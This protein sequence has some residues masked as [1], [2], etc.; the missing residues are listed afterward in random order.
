MSCSANYAAAVSG[1]CAAISIAPQVTAADEKKPNVLL[2]ITDDQGCGDFGFTGNKTVQTPNIDRLAAESARFSNFVAAPACSPSRTSLMTGRN[3]LKTG[4]WGVGER[5]NQLSD[6]VIMPVFFKAA[7][8]G[9]GYFGKRDGIYQQG[10]GK[11]PWELGWD[12]AVM[13]WGYDHLD[14]RMITPGGVVEKKGWTCDIDVENT[15]DYIRRQNGRPWLCATAFIIPHLPW[16]PDERFAEPFRKTGC[17]KLLADC[18]GSIAQMDAAAGRLLRG[19]DELGCAQNTIIVFLS[20]NGPSYH[21]MSEADIAIRNP[22]HLRDQKASAWENGIRVPLLIRWPSHIPA[23]ERTRFAG[24]EDLLPTLMDLT[25]LPLK[26]G[27]EHLPFD[28]ISLKPILENP[29]APETER[30]V[31]RTAISGTGMIGGDQWNAPDDPAAVPMDASHLTLRGPRF[32]FHQF[33]G[34]KTA[35]YDLQQDISETNDV[36]TQFP[37][38][39]E[40]YAG[41][42]FR[43]YTAIMKSGRACRMPVFTLSK[44]R[45]KIPAVMAQHLKGGA[46]AVIYQKGGGHFAIDG[47][48]TERDTVEYGLLI[49]A[50]GN[51]EVSVSGQQLADGK[52]W[53]LTMGGQPVSPVSVTSEKISFGPIALESGTVTLKI[54]LARPVPG[55]AEPSLITELL[56]TRVR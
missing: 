40:Q 53:V 55:G 38:V 5:N 1:L 52:D 18:Y 24:I 7:G 21:G 50:P 49:P 10:S 36:S 46:Q 22:A 30:T 13:V 17:S 32:K 4:V 6:E 15:L 27:P 37:E 25:G 23:G 16:E 11:N 39:T 47:F 45:L 2:I 29:D 8:Y 9:T 35:L 19:L 56:V 14:P 54:G 31:L 43:E 26:R 34:G 12:E 41:E 3:Y 48:S 33:K 20:D 44:P 51:F 28:G 42:L